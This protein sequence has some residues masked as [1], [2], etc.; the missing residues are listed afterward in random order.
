LEICSLSTGEKLAC[1]NS[2][3]R[4][5][6]PSRPDRCPLVVADSE[7]LDVAAGFENER[8]IRLNRRTPSE[9]RPGLEEGAKIRRHPRS[10]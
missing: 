10:E 4:R 9:R 1:S 6:P 3:A 7:H 8:P 2:L 5:V